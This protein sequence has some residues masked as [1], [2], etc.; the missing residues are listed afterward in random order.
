MAGLAYGPGPLVYYQCPHN[1]ARPKDAAD[2]PGHPRTVKAPETRLDQIT[3]LF[4]AEHVF[5]PRRAELLAAQLPAT[6]QAAEADRD[7]QA[8]ALTAR[9]KQ[10]DTAQKAQ[11]LSL[12]QLSPDPADTA[13]AAMRARI[14]DRF[15]ELHHQ[16]EQAQA[17]LDALQAVTPKAADPTL[18]DE[19][20]LAGNILP[21][22]DPALKARL[23]DAFDLQILWNKPGRQVTV[24]A[25]I[26]DATL[27][28]LPALLNPSRDGYDDTADTCS[29][30]TTDVEDLFESPI[31]AKK[32][33]ISHILRVNCILLAFCAEKQAG[34]EV[35]VDLRPLGP[36]TRRCSA[37]SALR[38]G[39]PA[40]SAHSGQ[41]DTSD[42]LYGTCPFF[43]ILAACP[44]PVTTAARPEIPR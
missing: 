18:L 13:A 17:Q 3:G 43:T 4:F 15:A 29:G 1:P 39:V 5:G 26:T 14:T 10:L 22:L 33:L 30:E 7:A 28:A 19:L 32:L 21:G 2:H 34:E 23:F 11:I 25:E 31:S 24:F 36:G 20:P 37:R 16:R 44:R 42:R 6:D 9:L 35:A 40:R 8:A 27:R 12:E 38:A 41:L